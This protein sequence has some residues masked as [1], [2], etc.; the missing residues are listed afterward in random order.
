MVS[1]REMK[2]IEIKWPWIYWHGWRIFDDQ[3][4]NNRKILLL[5]EYSGFCGGIIISFDHK[6]LCVTS[7]IISSATKGLPLFKDHLH[8]ATNISDFGH[9]V[10]LTRE[11]N[12]SNEVSFLLNFFGPIWNFNSLLYSTNLRTWKAQIILTNQLNL[13]DD[14]HIKVPK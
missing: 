9:S 4:L 6:K 1:W 5:S 10:L 3:V 14:K 2:W 12:L 13:Y 11:N 7:D 8:S